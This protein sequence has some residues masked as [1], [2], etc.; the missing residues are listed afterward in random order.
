[1]GIQSGEQYKLSID[2]LTASLEI[3]AIEKDHNLKADLLI[4]I[5]AANEKINDISAATNAYINAIEEGD[6]GADLNS[7]TTN[8]ILAGNFF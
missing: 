7:V 1:M 5:G 8:Y 6:K 3:A 4:G 2:L